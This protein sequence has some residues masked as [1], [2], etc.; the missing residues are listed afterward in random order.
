MSGKSWLMAGA[1]AL[2]IVSG[3]QSLA[4]AAG[5][6]RAVLPIPPA[7]FD[8]DIKPN[9]V[10]SRPGTG[11]DVRAPEGAPNVFMFMSDDVGF[12]MTSAFGGPV[13][14]PNIERLARTGQRYNRFHTTG[15]CS[16]SRAALL[17]GRN[18]HQ[19]GSG[20][21]SDI[22]TP[23]PG[24]T[25]RIGRDTATIAQILRL[26]GY[27]TAMFGKHHN[28]PPQDRS[29]ASNH[30]NWPTG[31][32]FEYFFGFNSGDVD[33]YSP[34]LYRGIHRTPMDEA[35]G[36]LLDER[37]ADDII[38]YVH[39]QRA[40]APNKPFLIYFAPGTMHA[41]HQAP[42]SYI[43]RFKG[44]FDMGWDQ[45]RVES[46]RR[47]IAGGIVPP[48]TKLTPRPDQ[49]PAWDS[50]S[51]KE[52]AFHARQMEVAAAQLVF[53]DEQ[54]GRIFDELDRMGETDRTL[55]AF[56]LGDNGG[57]GESGP[58]G[59]LNELRTILTQNERKEWLLDSLEDQ[60]GPN[61][62]QNYS[63]AWAWAANAPYPWVKQ[64]ASML[65]GIRNG[66]ILSYPQFAGRPGTICSQFGHLNDIAPT[67]LEA[68]GIPAPSQVLG[69]NQKPMDG[70]SLLSSLKTCQ[71]D[72]P[73]TQYFEITGKMGLYHNGWFLSG[74]D[75]RESWKEVGP[76]GAK[77]EV[78]WSLYDL[79][80]DFSQS[81]DLSQQQPDR[82][83]AMMATFDQEAKKNNVYPIDHRFGAARVDPRLM[84]SLPKSYRYWG[85]TVSVPA[86]GG[87][88]FLA[89]RPFTVEADLVLDSASA[90]GVV[91]ALAS[92]FGGWSLYLDKGRPALFWSRSTDPA[93]QAQVRAARALPKGKSTLRMRF[94]TKQPGSPAEAILSSGGQEYGRVT[95]PT[96]VLF[97]AGNGET[98]DVGRDLGVTVTDYATPQGE[99]E[100]DIT[101]VRIDLD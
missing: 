100:G 67:I 19:T 76:G 26:N 50:L 11:R 3:G 92:R 83:N 57:S 2:G 17:T 95:I 75:G 69:T 28:L 79:N 96:N 81:T 47:Q 29:I 35:P 5:P 24:Y 41:P 27:S 36:K 94:E 15:I 42:K 43:D 80:T 99:I 40:A 91:L 21:L 45:L 16:P 71:P 9:A 60:G 30:D 82:L 66:A 62:Y 73:R 54:I 72:K 86:A 37:F 64:Y 48:D 20:Y 39:N 101:Q 7:A 56:V 31:L 12:A 10:D 74:E 8:G 4:Q 52:R 84:A 13:P 63:V 33:Q 38:S 98:L 46:W 61:T 70:Q 34:I 59:T 77:P 58:G 93:E 49:I 51:A 32:G 1:A 44:K 25:G 68:T 78:K 23:Y 89:M 90:S 18:H 55:F 88:P 97:P 87:A 14:S 53:Q 6:D 65:G 85:K 22:P